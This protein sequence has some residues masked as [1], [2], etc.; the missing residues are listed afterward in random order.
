MYLTYLQEPTLSSQVEETKPAD[1]QIT[2]GHM[3]LSKPGIPYQ[4]KIPKENKFKI[5]IPEEMKVRLP[6]ERPS[7]RASPYAC[8]HTDY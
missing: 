7:P 6:L 4:Y 1:H 8:Q 3:P 2:P 5:K